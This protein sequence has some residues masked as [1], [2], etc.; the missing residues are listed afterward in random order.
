[1]GYLTKGIRQM[2]ANVTE[3]MKQFVDRFNRGRPS[4]EWGSQSKEQQ[5]EL[6]A[7]AIADLNLA[8][9]QIADYIDKADEGYRRDMAERARR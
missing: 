5:I 6:L 3:K 1:M 7:Q 8:V 2:S 9:A 4:G